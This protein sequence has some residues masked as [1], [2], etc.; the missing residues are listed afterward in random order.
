MINLANNIT[1]FRILLIPFFVQMILKYN[2]TPLGQ[3]GHYRWMAVVIFFTAVITDA[4][5]GFIARQRNQIT[6][7]G[8]ALDP[9]ADKLLLL[10]AIVILSIKG[11]LVTFPLWFVITVLSRDI[12]IVLGTLMLHLFNGSVKIAPSL[13]G[14]ATTVAQMVTIGWVMLG[15]AQPQILWRIAGFLTVASGF[16]YI[17]AGSR[18]INEPA[19]E[20]VK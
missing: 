4:I 13:L 16:A 20:K 17:F 19:C 15:L 6:E 3:G 11:H 12:I 14:K 7:L 10:S 5:D 1:I 2:Q 8:K 9:I 18:Q